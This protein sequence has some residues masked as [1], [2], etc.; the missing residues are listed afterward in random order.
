MKKKH[1]SRQQRPLRT[2]EAGAPLQ[3]VEVIDVLRGIAILLMVIYHFCFDLNQFGV[4]HAHFNE[5]PFW[6]ASRTVILSLFLGLVG[7][8]QILC[9]Q[10]GSRRSFLH[11][12]AQ[13]AACCAA[14]S[15]ASF[16]MFPK[17]W[18][19]FGVLHFILVASFLGR[20]FL[21][22]HWANLAL[23]ALLVA[24]GTGMEFP[25]FNHPGLQWIGLMTFKPLT[26][27][28]VPL[29]P[30]FGVVLF[31]MFAARTLLAAQSPWLSWRARKNPSRL[32]ALAG[33]HSLA[34]YMIHQPLMLGLLS[35]W[36]LALN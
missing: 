26:E 6:L 17:S 31:G 20:L 35:L 22:W 13:L 11:R 30:W 19:F 4:I 27:D 16:V 34:I 12:T 28:Y 33:R 15:A 2:I 21:R 9:G 36:R 5:E 10:G 14:V 18:I 23:G 1:K 3:R 24:I 25:A 29:L 7:A 32:A 8:S